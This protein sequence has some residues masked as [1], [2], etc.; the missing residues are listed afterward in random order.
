MS[1]LANHFLF[2]LAPI[3]G[4]DKKF[5]FSVSFVVTTMAGTNNS[6]GKSVQ[7]LHYVLESRIRI[8]GLGRVT[9]LYPV[10]D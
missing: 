6:G 10:N 5:R 7:N 2:V 4:S 1:E 8:H 3:G 9:E